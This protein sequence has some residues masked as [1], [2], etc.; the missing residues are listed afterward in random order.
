MLGDLAG[1]GVGRWGGRP[2]ALRHGRWIGF[3]AP[4]LAR[5]ER[6]LDRWGGLALLLTRSLLS[7]LGPAANLLAGAT[8]YTLRR[9]LL[10]DLVGRLA[11]VGAYL[12]LGYGFGDNV[13]AAADFLASIG[14][15]LVALALTLGAAALLLRSWRA[16]A[17]SRPPRAP[18]AKGQ[19]VASRPPSDPPAAATGQ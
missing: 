13:D 14:G 15:L 5:A 4:R 9:F 2:F 8:G 12:G 17:N 3:S 7:A 16:A 19:A 18:A 1:Y 6:A 11:W 10:Y